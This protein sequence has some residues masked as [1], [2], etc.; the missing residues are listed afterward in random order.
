MIDFLLIGILLGLSAGF[1]PGPLLTLVV[2]E[3]LQYGVAAGIKVA[4]TPVIADLP[5]IVAALLI[6]S[7]LSSFDPVLGGIA[8]LGGLFLFANGY[9]NIRCNGHQLKLSEGN[10]HSLLKGILANILNPH[11]YLFWFTIGASTTGKALEQSTLA[12]VVFIGSFY[13]LLVG[14]KMVLALMVGRSRSFL[15]GHLYIYTIRTLGVLLCLFAV[16]ITT[17]GLELLGLFER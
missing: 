15:S 4:I 12:A 14:C 10:S 2:S 3:T 1:A 16:A 13:L 8:L 17:E 5:I 6:V 7:E 11:P 9:T